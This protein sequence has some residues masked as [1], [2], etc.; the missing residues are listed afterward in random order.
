MH[1]IQFFI[2]NTP[3]IDG[4]NN[5]PLFCFHTRAEAYNFIGRLVSVPRDAQNESEYMVLNNPQHLP[6]NV[7]RPFQ[8]TL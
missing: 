3:G 1:T 6:N 8:K 2:Y 7:R 4:S 5:F